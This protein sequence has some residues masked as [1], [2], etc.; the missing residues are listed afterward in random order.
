MMQNECW[1]SGNVPLKLD[2]RLCVHRQLEAV[3]LS[4]SKLEQAASKLDAYS[5]QL[6]NRC[7]ALGSR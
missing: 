4:L 7:R 5:K 2:A 6:E 3:D 1:L